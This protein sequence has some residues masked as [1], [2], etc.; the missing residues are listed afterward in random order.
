MRGHRTLS[1]RIGLTLDFATRHRQ[2]HWQHRQPHMDIGH[3]THHVVHV[4]NDV[5]VDCQARQQGQ[6][7]ENERATTTT[8]GWSSPYQGFPLAAVALS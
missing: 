3:T 2:R 4:D 5:D 1:L 8:G 6:E 7:A